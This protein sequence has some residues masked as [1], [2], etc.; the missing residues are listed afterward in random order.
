M[1]VLGACGS[2]AVRAGVDTGSHRRGAEAGYIAWRPFRPQAKLTV[3]QIQ[4]ARA[5]RATG[6]PLVE[7]SVAPT[8]SRTPPFQD[9][10][11]A[12]IAAVGGRP[13]QAG[14]ASVT[15]R[16]VSIG[17]TVGMVE[18]HL[19]EHSVAQKR[20]A[21]LASPRQRDDALG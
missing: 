7:R 17:R 21:A 10:S 8:K 14:P 5:R 11:A 15:F 20:R 19:M 12:R 2:P 1:A 3:H 9:C 16:P 18:A 4:Q 6:E 13:S